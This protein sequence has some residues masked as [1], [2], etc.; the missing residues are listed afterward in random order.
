[1]RSE[2]A[3]LARERD[4]LRRIVDRDLVPK[5]RTSVAP[6]AASQKRKAFGLQL[7][8]QMEALLPEFEKSS[9]SSALRADW[10]DR[11]R[12]LK[13]GSLEPSEAIGRLFDDLAEQI[14]LTGRVTRREGSFTTTSGRTVRGTFLSVGG[15]LETFVDRN[16]ELAALRTSPV[17]GWQEQLPASSKSALVQTVGRAEAGAGWAYLPLLTTGAKP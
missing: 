4:S 6:D 7:A 16:G 15:L 13:A 1:M 2:A 11:I 12:Q 17:Q 3:R 9:E 14:D 5:T 10:Q 8:T